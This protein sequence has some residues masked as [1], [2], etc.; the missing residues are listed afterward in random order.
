MREV[1]GSLFDSERRRKRR[2]LCEIRSLFDT[3]VPEYSDHAR[4]IV[5]DVDGSYL[6]PYA[7]H[8]IVILMDDVSSSD[9][10]R[11][12]DVLPARLRQDG[13]VYAIHV[14]ETRA[15]IERQLEVHELNGWHPFRTERPEH[16]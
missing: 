13:R 12:V 10:E 2:M 11:I 9:L 15:Y 16:R 7:N 14:E 4:I 8:N 1:Q 3:K 6:Q 5:S